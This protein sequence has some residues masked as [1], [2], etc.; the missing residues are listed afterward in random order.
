M[1]LSAKSVTPGFR[2]EDVRHIVLTHLHFDHADGLDDFA[3][4]TVH[5]LRRER[6]SAQAQRTWL[7]RQ[8][9]PTRPTPFPH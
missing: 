9:Y 3:L 7:D 5:M 8:R 6:D 1:G 2:R 4:A